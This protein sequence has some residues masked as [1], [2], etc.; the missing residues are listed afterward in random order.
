MSRVSVQDNH[1]VVT[2]QGIRKVLT[3]KSELS[4][5]LTSIVHVTACPSEE[6][7]LEIFKGWRIGTE[8]LFYSGGT[9]YRDGNKAFYDVK[10]KEDAVIITLENEDFDTLV[11]GVDDPDATAEY[12]EKAISALKA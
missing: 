11:I 6:R 9:F 8:V 10:K 4:I 7:K 12:I 5:P 2:M 1:L 3:L